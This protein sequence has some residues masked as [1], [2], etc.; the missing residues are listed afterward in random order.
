LLIGGPKKKSVTGF[1]G[2]ITDFCFLDFG[3]TPLSTLVLAAENDLYD[4]E[5]NKAN[6][7][8]NGADAFHGFVSID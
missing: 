4:E 8:V 2:L 5:D 6:K 3:A 1:L 7:D